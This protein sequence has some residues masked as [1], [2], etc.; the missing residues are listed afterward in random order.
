LLRFYE[1]QGGGILIDH[2]DIR[3]ITLASLRR[4]IG[5]LNQE[6]ILFSGT[7]LENILYGDPSASY[8]QAV[9]AALTAHAHDFVCRLPKKYE[10]QVGERGLRLSPG[11]KQRIAMARTILKNPRILILDEPAAALDETSKA[12]VEENLREL[13][14]GRTTLI[15]SHDPSALQGAGRFFYLEN[16]TILERQSTLIEGEIR[17]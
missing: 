15:I 14:R 13:R 8:P 17:S 5:L 12:I 2:H 16:G 10:T 6:P 1:V 7:I 11:Q 3:E 4:Q 9:E